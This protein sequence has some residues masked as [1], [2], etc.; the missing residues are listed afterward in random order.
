[1]S[2]YSDRI[3][4]ELKGLVEQGNLLYDS[5]SYELATKDQ[6]E[7][8]R[9]NLL[10]R[11]PEIKVLPKFNSHYETWYSKALQY[12]RLFAPDRLNDFVT[13]YKNEK[14]K[15]LDG[16]SYT[17]SDAIIGVTASR[18]GV[19]IVGPSAALPKVLQQI[20]ILEATEN[21]IDSS[22]NTLQF[23]VRADLFD[24]ELD[25]AQELFKSGFFRAAGAMCGVVLEKHLGQVCD[26]HEIVIKK[27]SPARDT[28]IS[29]S[30]RAQDTIRSSCGMPRRR[31]I[32]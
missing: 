11:K 9:K 8:F 22:I 14:R 30:I 26:K 31:K 27:K 6:K 12:I 25:A 18:G 17:I 7:T 15:Q 32:R 3:K 4:T 28:V 1:M 10:E 2:A 16:L 29:P 20:S 19:Q 21:L 24:S 5:F 13:L 23:S